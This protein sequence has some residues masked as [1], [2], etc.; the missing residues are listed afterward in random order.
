MGA[1][2]LRAALFDAAGTLIELTEPVGATY[3]RTAAEF[4]VSLP[5]WRLDDAFARILRGAPP[6][7]FPDA[8]PPR[9]D[10]LERAWWRDVVRGTFRA[11]DGTARF[12]DFDAFFDA[13]YAAFSRAERWRPAPGAPEL[14]RA[15]R[16]RGL[17]TGIVSNF[18]GRLPGI[19]AGLGLAPLLDTVVLPSGAGAAKPDPR[20]FR[21]ALE[22]L[23]VPAEAALFVGDD[24]EQD[25]AGARAAGLRAID[26]ASLATLDALLARLDA[27][28]ADGGA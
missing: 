3:S 6:M 25:V 17:A 10:A 7:V 5:A 27:G 12:D 13:L 2:P 15:L 22:R 28:P 24:A 26:V 21:V 19:L 18:D 16:E 20:I 23:D 9:V 11:A 14:L 8:E 1:P 4:G